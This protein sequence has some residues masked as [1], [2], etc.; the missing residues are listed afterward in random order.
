MSSS[1]S[2]EAMFVWRL[3]A[4]GKVAGNFVELIKIKLLYF[5]ACVTWP[6]VALLAAEHQNNIPFRIQC[7]GV[8]KA[9]L[10]KCHSDVKCHE[11][12]SQKRKLMPN[13]RYSL[14]SVKYTTWFFSTSQNTT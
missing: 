5:V 3:F 14:Q 13:M 7:R 6:L 11:D 1:V 4:N 8:S 12:C 9:K 2:L 10:C